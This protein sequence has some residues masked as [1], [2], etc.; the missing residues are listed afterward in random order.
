MANV[1]EEVKIGSLT[2]KN[3]IFMAPMTRSRANANGVQSEYAAEYYGQRASAGLIISEA[4]RISEQAKGFIDTPGIYTNEQISAWKKITNTVHKN[5]GKIFCQLWHVGRVSHTS[6]LPSGEQPVAPSA[7]HGDAHTFTANGFERVSEPRALEVNEI[8]AIVQDFKNAAKAS[9]IA[10]FDGV[11]VHAAN[12]YLIDQFLRDKTNK[13]ADL[14]GGSSQNRARFL[15]EV[16]EAV[17]EIWPSNLIGVRLTPTGNFNDI[18]D[19]D[20]Y[21]TFSYIYEQLFKR[22]AAYIHVCEQMPG[23]AENAE[24]SAEILTELRNKWKGFY[25]VNGGFDFEQGQ[26]AVQSGYADAVSYGRPFISNPDLPLRF[27]K[28][29]ALNEQDMSTFYGGDHRGYT[30]YP[31]T[32]DNDITA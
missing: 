31:F 10:G 23:M 32:K 22:G 26:K 18:E 1:F 16:L 9:K 13:R 12:G 20:P 29:L 24:D 5:G 30:D 17:S 28:G 11:E 6:L 7:I 15:F 2:L 4:T 19:S 3:R 25:L 14:Y 21:T 27:K 8:E